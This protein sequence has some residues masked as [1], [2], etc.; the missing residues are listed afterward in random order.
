MELDTRTNTGAAIN[1]SL[2]LELSLQGRVRYTPG[3]ILGTREETL[4]PL[5]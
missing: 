3:T 2:T 4:R 1:T 5:Y